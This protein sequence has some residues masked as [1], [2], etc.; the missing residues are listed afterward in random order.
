MTGTI[1]NIAAV[2]VG[3]TLGLILGARLP[4]RIRD[5]V[6]MGL[7]LFT[8]GVGIQ[9]FLNT[10]NPLIVLGSLLIGGILGE[11]WKIET[12]LK[13]LGSFLEQK[14]S[15][16]EAN[17]GKEQSYVEE[18]GQ[19]ES[20]SNSRCICV[21]PLENITRHRMAALERWRTVDDTG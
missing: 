3:G 7:G 4:A 1:I 10:T 5:T 15:T 13:N 9:M 17:L 6:I 14:T 12:R 18:A 8:A 11:W 20:G 21:P 16:N 19:A 2:L